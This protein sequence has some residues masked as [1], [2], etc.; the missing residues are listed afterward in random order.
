M[1]TLVVLGMQCLS[2]VLEIGFLY[3]KIESGFLSKYA[4]SGT[5]IKTKLERSLLYGKK[6]EKL[7]YARLLKGLVADDIADLVVV[8][9]QHHILFSFKNALSEMS[10]TINLVKE[11]IQTFKRD[12]Y[13][14]VGLPLYQ[15]DAL[16][17]NLYLYISNDGIQAKI[18]PIIKEVVIKFFIVLLALVILLYLILHKFMEKP[19]GQYIGTL[20]EAIVNKNRHALTTSGI[21]MKAFFEIE[22]LI[23]TLKGNRW[24]EIEGSES[25]GS[26]CGQRDELVKI[27]DHYHE[28]L[29]EIRLKKTTHFLENPEKKESLPWKKI[30]LIIGQYEQIKS[31]HEFAQ[32]LQQMWRDVKTEALYPWDEQ[33]SKEIENRN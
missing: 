13:Y 16:Q 15:N 21:K 8:S 4:L 5:M 1:A 33:Q 9:Q 12:K 2:C 26:D 19:F 14:V 23:D 31:D 18:V 29:K 27:I 6:I 32:L 7:N 24:L 3:R 10:S 30:D 11:G 28:I 25:L 17:G 20:R 22:Q